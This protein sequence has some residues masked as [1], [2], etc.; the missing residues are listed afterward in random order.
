M[1]RLFPYIVAT[2]AV[3]L[4][5]LPFRVSAQEDASTD[6]NQAIFPKD[7]LFNIIQNGIT[8]IIFITPEECEV[9][10][11]DEEEDTPGQSPDTPP[12][13]P[14]DPPGHGV[15]EE[16]RDA[17]R[18]DRVTGRPHH[19]PGQRP[20]LQRPFE[21]R[22]DLPSGPVDDP[23]DDR[24]DQ[25]QDTS[26]DDPQPPDPEEPEREGDEEAD[27]EEGF[28]AGAF[29]ELFSGSGTAKKLGLKASSLLI[30]FLLIFLL[31]FLLSPYICSRLS[32]CLFCDRFKALCRKSKSKDEDEDRSE[33]DK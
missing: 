8:E 13:Q 17:D 9:I 27:Q 30:L 26:P 21:V 3:A 18:E 15:S 14:D 24:Q 28:I 33:D 20:L 7:C 19:T 4:I 25:D 22:E 12:D 32:K 10:F 5:I 29:R 31:I 23:S 1:S 11:E 2:V 6:L 16:R